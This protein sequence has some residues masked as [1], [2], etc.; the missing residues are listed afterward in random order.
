MRLINILVLIFLIIKRNLLYLID[1]PRRKFNTPRLFN[2]IELKYKHD[3]NY[4]INNG[5]DQRYNITENNKLIV[6]NKEV[7]L[8][9][10]FYKKKILDYLEDKN[11]DI[12]YKLEMIEKNKYLFN[13]KSKYS[14]DLYK[15]LNFDEFINIDIKYKLE[16]GEKNK[17]LFNEKSEYSNDLYKDSNFD[18]FI[19]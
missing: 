16:M 15:D 2:N 18:E 1:N 5:E 13:E 3:L 17:S 11:I 14:N 7:T 12:K 8:E 6:N 10:L 19:N 9:E 4:N